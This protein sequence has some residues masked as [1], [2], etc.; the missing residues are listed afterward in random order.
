MAVLYVVLFKVA[1]PI[2]G[3]FVDGRCGAVR[4]YV[5]TCPAGSVH[6]TMGLL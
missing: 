2:G 6:I 1:N 3:I 5:D 4:I